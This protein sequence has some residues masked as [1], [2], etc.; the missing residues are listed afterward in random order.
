MAR[1]A[2]HT[3][4]RGNCGGCGQRL[5]SRQGETRMGRLRVW[6][7]VAGAALLL[8]CATE[9]PLPDERSDPIVWPSLGRFSSEAEFQQYLR[10]VQRL[11]EQTRRRYSSDAAGMYAQAD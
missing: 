7:A 5:A 11:R 1:N 8:A 10:D 2:P 6:S 3:H 4:V 9:V